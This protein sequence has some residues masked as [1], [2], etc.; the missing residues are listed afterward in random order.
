MSEHCI[1]CGSVIPEGRQVCPMCEST[2][3]NL[4]FTKEFLEKEKL[5]NERNRS[6]YMDRPRP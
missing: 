3:E 1:C 4:Y 5:N 2:A 6:S